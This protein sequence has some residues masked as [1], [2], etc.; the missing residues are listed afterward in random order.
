MNLEERNVKV[1]EG[2]GFEHGV[3]YIAF[4]K[5]VVDYWYYKGDRFAR[6]LPNFYE[7]LDALDKWVIPE[8]LQRGYYVE[9]NQCELSDCSCRLL[10]VTDLPDKIT[11]AK[12]LATA[13]FEATEEVING[14]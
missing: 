3:V 12:T 6:H 4:G 10:S 1:A 5:M 7:S 11:Y 2:V 9:L 8:L 13:L 14:D